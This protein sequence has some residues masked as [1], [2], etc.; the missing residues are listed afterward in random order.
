VSN[1]RQR[2]KVVRNS[3]AVYYPFPFYEVD[4]GTIVKYYFFAGQRMVMKRNSVLMDSLCSPQAYLHNDHLGSPVLTTSSSATASQVYYAY[5]CPERSR[6]G[7]V[8]SYSSSF[9]TRYQFTGQHIDDSD[10]MDS[11]RSPLM[12]SLRSPLMDSLRS[13]QAYMNARYGVYPELV[14]G[15][16]ARVSHQSGHARSRRRAAHGLQPLHVRT[17]QSHE[18]SDPSGHCATLDTGDPD[19]NSDEE[20]WQ[21]AYEIYGLSSRESFA[22]QWK[23]TGD[24]W[25]EK[26]AK[27][28]F[29]DV[30][31]LKP[32]AEQ[33]RTEWAREVGLP[34]DK[35]V[36]HEP[37]RQPVFPVCETWD[38]PAIALDIGSLVLSVAGDALLAG[39]VAATEG[40]CA[41]IA[42]GVKGVDFVVTGL[43][44]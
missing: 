3:V 40:G 11:L 35:V 36:W 21:L 20:C 37:P 22:R 41:L 18:V 32:F 29:A 4:N 15:T 43:I 6:R 44:D 14:E 26:I 31:Y 12:D 39:C 42:I 13:P 16:G 33:Y 5:A 25:L 17:R 10:L 9:P 2:V 1:T 8:R 38:C 34:M 23:I 19:W 30:E 24:E 28:R 7:K 27:A